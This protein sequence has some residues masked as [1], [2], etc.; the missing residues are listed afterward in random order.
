M[1][2]DSA[3]GKLCVQALTRVEASTQHYAGTATAAI[4]KLPKRLSIAVEPYLGPT[5]SP[6]IGYIDVDAPLTIS[7]AFVCWGVHCLAAMPALFLFSGTKDWQFEYFSVMPYAHF[8]FRAPSHYWRLF[9]HVLG[10]GDW[11]HLRGNLVNLFL[12]GPACERAFGSFNLCKVIMYVALFSA[13]THF[14]FGHP[15]AVQLGASGVC[16]MLILLNSLIQLKANTIPVTFLLQI[17][18]WVQ[19]EVLD[20]L[21]SENAGVSN[22]AHLSGAL[23]GTYFGF[24]LHGAKMR[25]RVKAVGIEWLARAKKTK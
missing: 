22:L 11:G 16:F 18:L 6:Y 4:Q 9:S 2:A 13:L 15:A 1:P 20:Q 14:L 24:A 12:V 19:Q 7:F 5:V 8:S 23:V 10:H 25:E 17:Y 21:F 3:A